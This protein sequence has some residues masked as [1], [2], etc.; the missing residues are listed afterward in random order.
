MSTV[1]E[2]EPEFL[3]PYD[4]PDANNKEKKIEFS[5]FASVEIEVHGNKRVRYPLE[6]TLIESP[7]HWAVRPEVV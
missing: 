6:R 4:T 7:I 3:F 5:L 1:A 2:V